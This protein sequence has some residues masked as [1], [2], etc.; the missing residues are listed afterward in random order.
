MLDSKTQ[1]SIGSYQVQKP[2]E[3]QEK[4]ERRLMCD[5]KEKGVKVYGV[6]KV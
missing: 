4:V 6:F 1:K 5:I 3:E 2:V